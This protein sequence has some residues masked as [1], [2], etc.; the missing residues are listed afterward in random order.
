MNLNKDWWEYDSDTNNFLLHT[1]LKEYFPLDGDCFVAQE[2][3]I[4]YSD[5]TIYRCTLELSQCFHG[6]VYIKGVDVENDL[7]IRNFAV[8]DDNIQSWYYEQEPDLMVG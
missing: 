3:Y 7:N 5:N 6:L 2:F 4:L 1:F 8:G